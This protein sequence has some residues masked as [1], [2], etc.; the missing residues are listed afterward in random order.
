MEWVALTKL[1]GN[2]WPFG[3]G[4]VENRCSVFVALACG[5][6]IWGLQVSCIR[7]MLPWWLSCEVPGC[8]LYLSLFWFVLFLTLPFESICGDPHRN[9]HY[10]EDPMNLSEEHGT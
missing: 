10:P 2:L 1:W 9:K 4:V 5:Q 8:L 3:R 6:E 7:V